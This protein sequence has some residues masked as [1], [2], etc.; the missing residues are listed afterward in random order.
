MVLLGRAACAS[1]PASVPSTASPA[2]AGATHAEIV[3]SNFMFIAA[4]QTTVDKAVAQVTDV[5]GPA[6]LAL[7]LEDIAA[8]TYQSAV[9]AARARSS[10]KVAASIQAVEMQH[11]AILHFVLGQYPV[12]DAFTPLAGAGPPSDYRG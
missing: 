7:T 8:A 3:I 12:P 5:T 1:G 10:V 6:K 4:A 2:G 11:A 9:S